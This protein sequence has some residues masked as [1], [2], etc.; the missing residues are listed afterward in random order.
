MIVEIGNI[1]TTK[2]AQVTEVASSVVSARTTK[3][4]ICEKSDGP[5]VKSSVY[6]LTRLRVCIPT[7]KYACEMPGVQ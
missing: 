4:M 2:K 1:Y 3:K 5:N 6:F 7:I